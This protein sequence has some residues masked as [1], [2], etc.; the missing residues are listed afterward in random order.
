V[1]QNAAATLGLTLP[2]MLLAGADEVLE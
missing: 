2:A 1:N